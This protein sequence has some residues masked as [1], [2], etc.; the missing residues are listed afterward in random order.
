MWSVGVSVSPSVSRGDSV[1]RGRW[2]IVVVTVSAF[3]TLLAMPP[4]PARAHRPVDQQQ[5]N[6]THFNGNDR[7]GQHANCQFAVP[8]QTNEAQ[9]ASDRFDGVDSLYSLRALATPEA[10]YYDWYHCPGDGVNVFDPNGGCVLIARDIT[11]TLSQPAPGIAPVAAFEATYDIPS[12]IQTGKTFRALA[13]IE[14]PPIGQAHCFGDR[15]GVHFDDASNTADHAPT[16]S[17]QITQPAHGGA[18]SNAGFTAVAFTSESDIGRILFCLDI[19]TS[20]TQSEN[21]S[22]GQGCDPGSATDP[23]P[24]DSAPCGQVPAGADCWSVSIDPPDS[25]EFS[26][27]IVEQDDPTGPVSSGAGDCEGDTQVGG[28]GAN[29]GDDC[30]LDKIYVTSKDLPVGP[31]APPPSPPPAPAPPPTPV[32]CPGFQSD[33]RTQFVGTAGSDVLEG[34]SGPDIICGLGGNDTIRGLGRG[35]VLIGGAGSDA[36][37]GGRGK[38]TLR[39]GPGR[40]TLRGGRGADSLGGGPGGDLLDGGRDRDRCRGGRGNDVLRRCER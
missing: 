14:G 25:N 26:L 33:S 7:C 32:R 5:L 3:V 38:D 34:T 28:D 37:I 10:L 16:D 40:D 31:P 23:A 19:G 2:R 24:D 9:I 39:G 18:V 8:G 35:D 4:A 30:Q 6:P 17:G 15:T 36:L 29:S 22:P 12:N 1:E 13:C 21:A 11:P 27:G 20:A